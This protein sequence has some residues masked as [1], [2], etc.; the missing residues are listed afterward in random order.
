MSTRLDLDGDE[1]IDLAVGAHGSAVLLRWGGGGFLAFPERQQCLL[2]NSLFRSNIKSHFARP[3]PPPQLSKHSPDQRE[4]LLPATFHQCDSED[5]PERRQRIGLSE[6]YGLLHHGVP[7]PRTP[8][9]QLWYDGITDFIFV[10]GRSETCPALTVRPTCLLLRPLGVGH[11]GRQ[12]AVRACLVRRQLPQADPAGGPS[13]HGPNRL[14]QTP[15]PCLREFGRHF[16]SGP[17]AAMLT[18][19]L[20]FVCRRTRQITSDP[21]ASPSGSRSTTPR[22][23]QCWTRAG[24]PQLRSL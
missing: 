24:R 7:L 13:S 2:F 3:P 21:L 18:S 5:L 12:E 8:Q 10:N 22:A 14:L 16:A 1:L 4:S 19:S 6:C 20:V 9:Q 15:L 17:R 11:A 23:G